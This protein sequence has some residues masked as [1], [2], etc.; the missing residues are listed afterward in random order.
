[1]LVVT[2][3]MGIGDILELLRT[4]KG[5]NENRTGTESKNHNP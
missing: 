4:K 3:G 1:M 5:K 2:P